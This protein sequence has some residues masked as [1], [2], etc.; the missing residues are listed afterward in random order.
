MMFR[1]LLQANELNFF[2]RP[3]IVGAI[4]TATGNPAGLNGVD[5]DIGEIKQ[6]YDKYSDVKTFPY[7]DRE[8]LPSG[9]WD[10]M[11]ETGANILAGQPNAVVDAA[12]VMEQNFNDKFS[13]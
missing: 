13:Q 9:M 2:A 4:A 11:C 5:S 1:L 8:Y 3:E 10:V 12:K 6:Y 7:F